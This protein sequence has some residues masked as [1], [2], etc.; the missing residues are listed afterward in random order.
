VRPAPRRRRSP[1]SGE[2]RSDRHRS[3]R[4]FGPDS[5]YLAQRRNVLGDLRVQVKALNSLG[6]DAP[7]ASALHKIE[8]AWKWIAGPPKIEAATR[9]SAQ[10][11]CGEEEKLAAKTLEVY[12]QTGYCLNERPPT[13]DHIKVV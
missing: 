9:W 7:A 11:C 13:L 1:A 10:P 6:A 8:L 3:S 12:V 5:A 2:D 4:D